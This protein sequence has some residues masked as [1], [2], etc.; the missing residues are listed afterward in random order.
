[1]R[2]ES[3]D[4]QTT[5]LR[6]RNLLLMALTASLGAVDAISYLGLGKVFTAFITGNFVFLGLVAA[7]AGGPSVVSLAVTL[8]AFAAGVYLATRIVEPSRGSGV[9]PR[10]APIALGI[11]GVAQACFLAVWVSAAGLPA[12]GLAKNLLIGLSALAMGM[13]TATVHSLGLRGVF[14]TAVTGTLTVLMSG[15]AAPSRSEGTERLLVGSIVSLLVGAAVGGL[16]LVHA[17]TYAPILP[18]AVTI[19]VAATAAMA[20]RGDVND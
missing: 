4:G 19:V 5:D 3:I 8:A 9:G 11:A 12:S 7:G 14:T 10:R 16:L 13:Q 17:R 1:M 20:L 2:R 15:L 6:V 18:L